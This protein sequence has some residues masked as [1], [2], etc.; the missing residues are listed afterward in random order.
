MDT[1][2]SIDQVTK[3]DLPVPHRGRVAVGEP[4]TWHGA[5]FTHDT[6]WIY[7]LSQH[8]VAEID[9]ALNA[10]NREEIGPGR[11]GPSVFALPNLGTRLSVPLD[12]D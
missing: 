9:R 8:E 5:D 11:I 6:S 10:M 12:V 3:L 4:A 1:E 7:R 2:H